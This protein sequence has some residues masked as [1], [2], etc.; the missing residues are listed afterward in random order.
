[1]SPAREMGCRPG[2][3]RF[4]TLA[5][6]S[7]GLFLTTACVT[8]GQ[9]GST[10]P[11]PTDDA[12]YEPVLNRWS[13]SLNVFSKFQTQVG[14][15]AVLLTDEMRRAVAQRLSR[16]RG[17]GDALSVLSDSSG[18]VRL[19]VLVSVF[20]PDANY[21]NL[22]DRLL[23]SL[24]MRVGPSQLTPMYVRRISDKTLLQTLFKNI[25]QWSQDYLLV[26]D[27]PETILQ[28]DNENQAQAL[29]AEFIAQSA[30]AKVE[31]RWP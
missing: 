25:H 29:N 28:R 5:C 24:S 23:W 18:G 12:T 6:L 3:S 15:S 8:S 20:A 27:F 17:S 26:F 1:M 4:L 11:G 10:P 7:A 31:L 14:M 30:I 9:S 16:L 13:R 22:D 19:G 21:S 2:L